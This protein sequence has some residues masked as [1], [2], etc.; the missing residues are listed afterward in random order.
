M[1]FYLSFLGYTWVYAKRWVRMGASYQKDHM[2]RILGL[3]ASSSFQ[4]GEGDCRLSPNPQPVIPPK[5][6]FSYVIGQNWI[7]GY[8]LTQSL[9]SEWKLLGRAQ[10]GDLTDCRLPGSSVYGFPS[11][12]IGVGSHSFL[13]GSS[14]PRDLLNPGLLHCRWLLFQLSHQ[15]SLTLSVT[16]TKDSRDQL[17]WFPE[18]KI[19]WCAE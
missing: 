13:Q 5:T 18:L 9:A 12:T 19:H 3:G 8:P 6:L 14:Q 15:G 4:E 1:S 10:L 16:P 17:V 11:K 7:I 2:V